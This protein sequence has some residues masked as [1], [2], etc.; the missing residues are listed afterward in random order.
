MGTH[1]AIEFT[2]IARIMIPAVAIKR[3][4]IKA[5]PFSRWFPRTGDQMMVINP[6]PPFHFSDIHLFTINS[7]QKSQVPEERGVF[8]SNLHGAAKLKKTLPILQVAEL[9]LLTFIFH[10]H[11]LDCLE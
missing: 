6:L 10:P 4:F 1:S 2:A 9:R 8:H 3:D 11:K 7:A 5:A